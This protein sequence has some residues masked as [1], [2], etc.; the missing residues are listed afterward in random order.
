[1]VE[2]GRF[3]ESA[4]GDLPITDV[5]RLRRLVETYK[6]HPALTAEWFFTHA[7]L[8]YYDAMHDGLNVTAGHILYRLSDGFEEEERKKMAIY[9]SETGSMVI[10]R[11]GEEAEFFDEGEEDRWDS[12]EDWRKLWEGHHPFIPQYQR[13]L[14][15]GI[16]LT[17]R[18]EPK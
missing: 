5:P 8:G 2:K 11:E 14:P 17:H 3:S 4:F 9:P 13:Q 1:M 10:P 7:L 12:L 18:H 6:Q 15:P 16:D